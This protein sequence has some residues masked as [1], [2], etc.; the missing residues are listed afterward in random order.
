MTG[1]NLTTFSRYP[2]VLSTQ[3]VVNFNEVPVLAHAV[4]LPDL[5][6]YL[7]AWNDQKTSNLQNSTAM[8]STRTENG[9]KIVT[10]T[11]V[12]EDHEHPPA[13]GTIFTKNS[14]NTKNSPVQ[15][16]TA[17]DI[18]Y[19]QI[20]HLE[21]FDG[22]VIQNYSNSPVAS[23]SFASGITMEVIDS[24]KQTTLNER[25]NT[26]GKLKEISA[27]ASSSKSQDTSK[28]PKTS[29]KATDCRRRREKANEREKQRIV[30]LKNAM[31][32]LKNTIPAAREKTKIT[33]LEVLKLARDYINSLRSQLMDEPHSVGGNA[34]C[35]CESPRL[36]S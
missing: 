9:F 32:V 26:E 24:G 11:N 5:E 2:M 21:E 12:Q 30:V 28:S 22:E 31:N 4:W 10:T 3:Q 35:H 29:R 13:K 15:H 23:D 25:G 18:L 16:S 8:G 34:D 17:K 36:Q 20:V 6:D 14:F 33:K 27:V 1:S 7:Y 19:D